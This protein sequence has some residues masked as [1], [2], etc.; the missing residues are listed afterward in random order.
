MIVKYKGGEQKIVVPPD[1]VI[2]A[3]A[4]GD[5]SELKPGA[6]CRHHTRAEKAGRLARGQPRGEVVPQ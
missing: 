5:V 4:P 3:Y 2:R 6:Q 1:A